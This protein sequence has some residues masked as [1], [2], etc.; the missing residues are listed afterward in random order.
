[1]MKVFQSGFRSSEGQG[2]SILIEALIAVLI[3]SLGVL[4]LIGMQTFTINESMHSKYRTDAGYLANEIVGQMMLDKPNVANYA[5]G[6][7]TTSGLRTA[8]DAR[9][10]ERL[11]NGT[12]AITMNGSAVT[13][14]LT[15][16]NPNESTA[17]NYRSVSQV[18]F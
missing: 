6:A 12:S 14:V 1:M 13:I 4:A 16:R 11:P 17:H 2:G 15:W 18:I 5:D 3:F 8:W 9:V 7:S 10:A